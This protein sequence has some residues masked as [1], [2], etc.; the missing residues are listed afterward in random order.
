MIYA[1]DHEHRVGDVCAVKTCEY[2]TLAPVL[3]GLETIEDIP[4]KILG[5]S[6]ASAY[7]EQPIPDGWVI[8]SLDSSCPFFYEVEILQEPAEWLS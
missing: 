2:A 1:F 6:T 4:M 5:V 3:A 8:P 7:L